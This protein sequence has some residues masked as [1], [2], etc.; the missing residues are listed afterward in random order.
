MRIPILGW[1][2]RRTLDVEIAT[3]TM[4]LVRAT[5][6]Q[7]DADLL[8]DWMRRQLAA[9]ADEVAAVPATAP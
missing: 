3:Y 4:V 6:D 1:L 5:R 9:R 8:L 7:P 2:F